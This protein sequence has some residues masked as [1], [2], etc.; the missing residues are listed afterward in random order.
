MIKWI[1]KKKHNQHRNKI[2]SL[3]NILKSKLN[4]HEED[5]VN[6]SKYPHT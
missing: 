6:S 2:K 4:T 1:S 5:L 3:N